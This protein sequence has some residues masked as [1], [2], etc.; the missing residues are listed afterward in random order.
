MRDTPGALLKSNAAGF[1][2]SAGPSNLPMHIANPAECDR[3]AQHSTARSCCFH[4]PA[5]VPRCRYML[6]QRGGHAATTNVARGASTA[7]AT[8]AVWLGSAISKLQILV[9]VLV[10]VGTAR[11]DAGGSAEVAETARR[12]SRGERGQGGAEEA[13]AC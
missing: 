5:P 13:A 8:G 11:R 12:R 1:G 9:E 3:T 10:G 6:R 4:S 2:A 7:A